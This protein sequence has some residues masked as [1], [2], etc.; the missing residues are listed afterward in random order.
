[1][2]TSFFVV[3]SLLTFGAVGCDSKPK[4]AVEERPKIEVNAPGVKVDVDPD[5]G[6]EVKAPGVEV[7]A[8][9]N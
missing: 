7:E 5:K 3:L 6:I 2:K 9:K 4:P 8:P 1:M